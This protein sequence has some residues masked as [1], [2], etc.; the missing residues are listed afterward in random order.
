MGCFAWLVVMVVCI[1]AIAVCAEVLKKP[2]KQ[3]TAVTSLIVI[4]VALAVMC[5]STWACATKDDREAAKQEKKKQ[6]KLAR[7]SEEREKQE[8][9]E[10]ERKALEVAAFRALSPQEHINQTE[11]AIKI[12]DWP[13]AMEHVR[14]LDDN[15]PRKQKLLAVVQEL[16]DK[17][18]RNDPGEKPD[19]D[20]MYTFIKNVLEK[21][22][23]DPK[24]LEFRYS[25]MKAEIGTI[26]IEGKQTAIWRIKFSYR[27]NNA[28][29]AKV[30]NR[31]EIWVKRGKLIGVDI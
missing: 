12:Q 11:E 16:R 23:H 27:A 7:E 14:A 30:L 17:A 22:L 15:H 18:E 31:G 6:E 19:M 20:G 2:Q 10:A 25:D 8:K 1:V 29:G 28:F 26:P 4:L 9:I 5:I 21:E 13:K 3:K 24:S